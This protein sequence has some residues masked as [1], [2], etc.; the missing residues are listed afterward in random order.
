MSEVEE[1]G[2]QYQC[3]KCGG[4]T[5]S[6]EIAELFLGHTKCKHCGYRVLMKIR[7]PVV[8]KVKAV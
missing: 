8:R 3:A 4:I 1:A 6:A 2:V 5:T 7:P